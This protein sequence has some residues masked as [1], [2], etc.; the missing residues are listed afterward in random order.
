MKRAKVVHRDEIEADLERCVH[1]RE[2]WLVLRMGSDGIQASQ[3]YHLGPPGHP[4]PA[5][6]LHSLSLLLTSTLLLCPESGS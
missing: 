2:P 5:L 1:E 6:D 3:L 4:T